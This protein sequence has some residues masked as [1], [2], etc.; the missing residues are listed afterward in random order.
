VKHEIDTKAAFHTL[1]DLDRIIYMCRN[2][3]RL[4][5]AGVVEAQA[6]LDVLR[7]IVRHVARSG[8]ATVT[9]DMLKLEDL[10]QG[11]SCLDCGIFLRIAD[12]QGH[13]EGCLANEKI[14]VAEDALIKHVQAHPEDEP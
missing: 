3:H 4:S 7:G 8:K 6:L 10:R 1:S 5:S 2:G 9:G 12:K 13:S 14:L 11:N